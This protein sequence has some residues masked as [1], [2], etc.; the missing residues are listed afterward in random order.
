MR[1]VVVTIDTHRLDVDSR[2]P[3]SAGWRSVSPG[4]RSVCWGRY[5]VGSQTPI[6]LRAACSSRACNRTSDSS[7]S[8]YVLSYRLTP[9]RSYY[10]IIVTPRRKNAAVPIQI[11]T[12]TFFA[13]SA[14]GHPP[15]RGRGKLVRRLGPARRRPAPGTAARAPYLPTYLLPLRREASSAASV[16]CPRLYLR[17]ERPD[18]ACCEP[19]RSESAQER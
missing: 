18:G 5:E 13:P 11:I 2:S 10:T 3:P 4:W 6:L 8:T 14:D 19:A 16:F 12:H 9:S 15:P 17:H 1:V 7:S